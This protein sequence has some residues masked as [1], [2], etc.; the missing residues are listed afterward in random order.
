MTTGIQS[1]TGGL[2]LTVCIW[3]VACQ[4]TGATISRNSHTRHVL[5]CADNRVAAKIIPPALHV[6][7]EVRLGKVLWSVAQWLDKQLRGGGGVRYG[8]NLDECM[9]PQLSTMLAINQQLV[10]MD[11]GYATHSYAPDGT[12]LVRGN[13]P[14]SKRGQPQGR[15]RRP[16]PHGSP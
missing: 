2:T 14:P 13:G 3:E 15:Q 10:G 8:A 6:R 9:C 16:Q 1:V 5:I 11:V 12:I 4:I 7:V